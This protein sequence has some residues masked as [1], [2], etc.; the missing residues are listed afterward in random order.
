MLD[1]GRGRER[2]QRS[3]RCA[4]SCRATSSVRARGWGSSTPSRDKAARTR[5][6]FATLVASVERVLKDL[7]APSR[8]ACTLAGR[9]IAKAVSNFVR[10]AA[11][12][13]TPRNGDPRTD[14]LSPYDDAI[15]YSNFARALFIAALIHGMLSNRGSAGH[16]V[17]RELQAALCGVGTYAIADGLARDLHEQSLEEALRRAD[18]GESRLAGHERRRFAFFVWQFFVGGFH[19]D[20]EQKARSKHASRYDRVRMFQLVPLLC[21]FIDHEAFFVR[22]M[23][24]PV[25]FTAN[26]TAN[27]AHLLTLMTRRDRADMWEWTKAWTELGLRAVAALT[28]VAGVA[29][30]GYTPEPIG[31]IPEVLRTTARARLPA[32]ELH[33]DRF[34]DVRF[35]SPNGAARYERGRVL[36]RTRR[37]ASIAFRD[38]AFARHVAQRDIFDTEDPAASCENVRHGPS[39]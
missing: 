31:E 20:R 1:V 16:V 34:V 21:L 37:G 9:A 13:A 6:A 7:R 19:R 39:I 17:R 36:Y 35:R 30:L 24:R 4:G 25:V 5:L 3:R 23:L 15:S 2:A 18:A 38:G 8:D 32:T 22:P 33:P 10:A 29:Y 27:V 26:S 12:F 28:V 14:Y 11:T